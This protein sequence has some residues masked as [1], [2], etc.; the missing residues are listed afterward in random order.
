MGLT[1]FNFV[2]DELNELKKKYEQEAL[3]SWVGTFGWL[4]RNT[5]M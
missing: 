2:N 3:R 1:A 5:F 4:P